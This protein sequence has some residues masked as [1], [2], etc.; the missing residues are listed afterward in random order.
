MIKVESFNYQKAAFCILTVFHLSVN[1][2]V[3]EIILHLFQLSGFI[4]GKIQALMEI[5][6]NMLCVCIS[7][8][9]FSD[10]LK[11]NAAS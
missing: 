2:K 9:K 7:Y 5:N 6:E 11:S 8:L 10:T 1:N 4:S 3:E